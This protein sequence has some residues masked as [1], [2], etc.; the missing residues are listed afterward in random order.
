MTKRRLVKVVKMRLMD[1]QVGDIVHRDA[2]AELGWFEVAA[3]TP[4]STEISSYRTR[5]PTSR[6]LAGDYD[7]IGVQI[8]TDV[9]LPPQLP[10]AQALTGRLAI[11]SS[12]ERQGCADNAS[13]VLKLCGNDRGSNIQKMSVVIPFFG[14]ASADDDQV[15]PEQ[16]FHLA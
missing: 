12:V 14:H 10:R 15:G 6:F 5:P 3:K 9:E 1:A 13:L 2:T 7:T 16:I 11:T 4:C 8:V